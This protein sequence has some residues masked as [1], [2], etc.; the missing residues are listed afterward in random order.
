MDDTLFLPGADS[1]IVGYINRCGQPPMVVYE[2]S[3]LVEIFMAQ[4]MTD[5]E[6][7]EHI[8]VNIEGAWLGKGTPGILNLMP[9]EDVRTLI[10][11]V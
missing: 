5:E 2:H 6:A 8:S 3:K 9:G 1:A 11:F 7:I 4:G 10:D